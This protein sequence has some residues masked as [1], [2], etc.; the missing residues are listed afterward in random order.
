M[1]YNKKHI[2]NINTAIMSGFM[3]ATEIL[4]VWNPFKFR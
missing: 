3:F 1:V 2:Y 4:I